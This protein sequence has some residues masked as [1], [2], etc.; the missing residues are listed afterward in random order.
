MII[1]YKRLS[2]EGLKGVVEEFVTRDS[3]DYGVV[4]VDLE[5]KIEMVLKQLR[6]GEAFIIY[7]EITMTINIVLKKDIADAGYE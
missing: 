3:T 4:E 6:K 2:V 5:T 7:D 1:P